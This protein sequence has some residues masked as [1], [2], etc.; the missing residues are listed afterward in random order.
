LEKG[1]GVVGLDN[2]NAYYDVSLKE[3]R[4]DLLK[5]FEQFSFIRGDLADKSTVT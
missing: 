3:A 2:L 5:P 4:L 1:C